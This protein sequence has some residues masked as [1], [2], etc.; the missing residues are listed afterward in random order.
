MLWIVLG[1]AV[2]VLLAIII[3][4]RPRE[5]GSERNFL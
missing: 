2:L 5:M 1:I 3:K 4:P